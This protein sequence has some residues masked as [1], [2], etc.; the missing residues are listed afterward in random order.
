[1]GEVLL[2]VQTQTPPVQSHLNAANEPLQ[3]RDRQCRVG[4]R[5]LAETKAVRDSEA[6]IETGP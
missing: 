1:M 3:F 6:A 4:V 2:R 5:Q